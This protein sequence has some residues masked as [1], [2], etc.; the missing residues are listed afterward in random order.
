[1]TVDFLD[2]PVKS[3]ELFLERRRIHDLADLAVNL[4]PVPVHKSYTIVQV[5]VGSSH[6]CF[7]NLTL[8]E[9]A[10]SQEDIDPALLLPIQL[11]RQGHAVGGGKPLTQRAGGHIHPRNI[12]PVR[13]PLEAAVDFAKTQQLFRGKEAPFRQGGIIHRRG[14]ALAEHEDISLIP[15]GLGDIKFHEFKIQGCEYFHCRQGAAGMAGIGCRHHGDNVPAQTSGN[16][17]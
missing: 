13:M 11:C 5:I 7:P 17:P 3:G 10:V 2:M 14:V 16:G 12:F 1:M 6:H 4:Q 8:L 15:A 9:L